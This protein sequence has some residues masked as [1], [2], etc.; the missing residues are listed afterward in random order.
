MAYPVVLGLTFGPYFD[1][2]VFLDYETYIM[3]TEVTTTL[4]STAL[5][6]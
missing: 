4:M 2:P 5:H 6:P 1:V 3:K